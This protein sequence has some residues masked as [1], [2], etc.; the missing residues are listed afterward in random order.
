M[1]GEVPFSLADHIVQ[2]S[3]DSS[4]ILFDSLAVILWIC[5]LL[6]HKYWRPFYFCIIGYCVYYFVDA[7][8]WMQFMN[9]R[10][11]HSSYNPFLVQLWLQLGPGIIHPSFV[12]LMFE[13]VFGP[14]R[15]DIKREFW[16]VL[17]LL[18][19]FTPCL[20]QQSFKFGNLIEVGRTM[21]SQR[22]LFVLLAGIGYMILIQQKV[23]RKNLWLIFM[24][25]FGVE[26]CFEL[27]LYISD[28]RI[29]SMKTMIVDSIIEFNV[30]AGLIFY[31][32]KL[33]MSN[34]ELELMNYK[35]KDD[36]SKLV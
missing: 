22:W 8:L 14:Q 26:G 32:W 2:R 17:F 1:T 3:V 6:Y 20:L 7:I 11:I 10:W 30:G 19:Q 5:C 28:I 15:N 35:E 12:I 21:Q 34:Y 13:S 36:D 9:V 31:L 4:I 23:S 27:S 29:A 24:I 18:V 25:C 16:I 33:M